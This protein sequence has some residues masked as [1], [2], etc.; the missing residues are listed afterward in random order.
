VKKKYTKR[1]VKVVLLTPKLAKE[2]LKNQTPLQRPINQT[3]LKQ[4]V[5]AIKEGRWVFNGQTISIDCYGRTQNGQHRCMAVVLSGISIA[6][7]IAYGVDPES[8]QTIDTGAPRGLRDTFRIRGETYCTDL[9]N[10]INL[11]H[12]YS[13]RIFGYGAHT[14]IISEAVDLLE[15][16]PRIRKSIVH[17]LK[18]KYLLSVGIGTFLHY[19]FSK[20]NKLHAETFFTKLSDGTDLAKTDPIRVLRD[21]LLENKGKRYDKMKRPVLINNIIKCWNDY[22]QQV[23]RRKKYSWR[24]TAKTSQEPYITAR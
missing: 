2:L 21:Q 24:N 7:A 18:T 19:I 14:L 10:A 9:A 8:Y 13:T 11:Y 23:S 5:R 12:Q 1:F 4:L 16:N 6:I 22:R 17:A 20:R 3:K 15:E